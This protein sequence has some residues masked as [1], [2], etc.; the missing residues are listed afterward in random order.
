M[1]YNK[2]WNLLDYVFMGFFVT[3]FILNIVTFAMKDSFEVEQLYTLIFNCGICALMVG[4]CILSIMKKFKARCVLYFI[5]AFFCVGKLALVNEPDMVLRLINGI[6]I[7]I[8][9]MGGTLTLV[10]TAVQKLRKELESKVE[11]PVIIH[12]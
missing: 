2:A 4:L 7:M 10:F 9:T 1:N 12:P 6:L 8:F 3:L 11:K 5:G